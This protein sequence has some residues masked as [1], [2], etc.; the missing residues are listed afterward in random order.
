MTA[1]TLADAGFAPEREWYVSPEPAALL[2]ATLDTGPSS[3]AALALAKGELPIPWHWTCFLPDAPTAALGADGH[4][5]RRDEMA[6][7]PNRMW[8]G[9]AV[10]TVHSGASGPPGRASQ[11]V[12]RRGGEDRFGGDA[13]G[14]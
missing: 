6:A 4:P 14:S 9:G 10:T 8:V 1:P 12:G 5:R 2:A 3:V 13:S 11:R 7:F